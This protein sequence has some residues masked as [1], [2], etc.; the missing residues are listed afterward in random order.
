VARAVVGTGAP[1]QIC[2]RV[3]GH[4]NT[5][6]ANKTQVKSN[7]KCR[8]WNENK[9]ELQARNTNHTEENESWKQR[10]KEWGL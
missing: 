2:S 1:S 5:N 9:S 3:K 10:K 7:V 8:I 6:E 4:T